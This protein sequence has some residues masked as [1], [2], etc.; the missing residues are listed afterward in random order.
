MKSRSQKSAHLSEGEIR[1]LLERAVTATTSGIIITDPGLPDNP[2]IYTN[3]AFEWITGYSSEEVVGRNCRFLQGKDQEQEPLEE[4]RTAIREGRECRSVLRNYRKD[5]TLFWNELF[6]TPVR[7]E[8]GRIVNFIGVQNDITPRKRAEEDRDRTLLREQVAKDEAVAAR[9]R[10]SML[11][12]AGS[13]LSSSLDYA[14]TLERIPRLFVPDLAEWCLLDVVGDDGYVRHAS[15]AHADP[16]KAQLLANLDSR[17][18]LD[19]SH[20]AYEVLRAEDPLL[21]SEDSGSRMYVPLLARGRTLGV[22]T[23][24]AAR[25]GRNYEREDLMLAGNLAHRCAL[26]LDNARLYRERDYIART[27]QRSLL[28]HLPEVQGFEVGSRYRPVGEESEVGGDFYDLIQAPHTRGAWIATV[29]DVCGKGAVAAAITALVR[30]TVRA[31]ALREESPS[32]ILSSL[33]EA[34]LR[35]LAAYQFCTAACLRLEPAGSG[36]DLTLARGGHPAPF[37]LKVDGSV[38]QL[39][40]PGRVLGVFAAPDFEE[41][42][43]RLETGDT[44]LLYTDGVTEARAPG[45]EFFGEEK[46]AG[47]V[48][49][50]AGMSAH[51]VAGRILDAVLDH[52]DGKPRDDVAILALRVPEKS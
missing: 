29:G 19:D 43:T 42:T 10:L 39:G 2:I 5:G 44:V 41:Q 38:R 4:L 8:G 45:G 18:T 34:M 12:S 36:A 37:V 13:A 27:L 7:D 25:D 1:P 50:C 3:P 51:D 21:V 40:A 14:A 16:S 48:A 47:L 30:Y 33:N 24:A 35:E 28:P 9:K 11:A 23:L 22:I 17:N 15:G 49:S 32:S 46:L 52:A 20:P 31:V 26:A 6:V